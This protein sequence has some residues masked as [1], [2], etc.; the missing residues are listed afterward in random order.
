[1]WWTNL[2]R[3]SS[4]PSLKGLILLTRVWL[5]RIEMTL[6]LYSMWKHSSSSACSIWNTGRRSWSTSSTESQ[7]R[8]S[9]ILC[10][11]GIFREACSQITIPSSF[12][13]AIPWRGSPSLFSVVTMMSFSSFWT[14]C[15]GKWS[16]SSNKSRK[17]TTNRDCSYSFW[18]ESS[19]LELTSLL[20]KRFFESCGH[21][22]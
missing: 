4:P 12:K 21:I 7:M 22:F 2:W 8:Y 16:R 10:K 14:K 9:K 5:S 13:N 6:F 3:I 1:M 19:S 17:M 11:S 15:L 20:Y 18:P